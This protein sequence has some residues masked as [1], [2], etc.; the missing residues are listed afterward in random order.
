MLLY[1][2]RIAY[3]LTVTRRED[4][5]D[6]VINLEDSVRGN[7][8]GLL[9]N[10]NGDSTDDFVMPNGIQVPVNASDQML[11]DFGQSCEFWPL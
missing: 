10:F 1:K 6:F 5:L 2:D 3:V 7:T 8:R 9:G 4:I 11:H